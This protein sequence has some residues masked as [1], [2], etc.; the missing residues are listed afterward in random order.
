MTILYHKLTANTIH[1]DNLEDEEGSPKSCLFMPLD[2]VLVP[3]F[4]L[5]ACMSWP[6]TRQS[7]YNT[8][9]SRYRVWVCIVYACIARGWALE[10]INNNYTLA[11][12]YSHFTGSLVWR[13]L[14]LFVL[15]WILPSTFTLS[16]SFSF[17]LTVASHLQNRLQGACRFPWYCSTSHYI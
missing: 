1:L 3:D 9:H 13:S 12:S 8:I 14:G 2:L 4:N 6:S 7:I 17:W 16:L 15:G 11:T 5:H 10:Y